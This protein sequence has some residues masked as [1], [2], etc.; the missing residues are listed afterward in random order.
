MDNIELEEFYAPA[1]Q[2]SYVWKDEDW[3]CVFLSITAGVRCLILK[4]S[5]GIARLR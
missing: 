2:R 4:K 1:E 3:V 5:Q